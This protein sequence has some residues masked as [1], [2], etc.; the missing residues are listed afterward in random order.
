M[1]NKLITS[2]LMG[3][4]SMSALA[5]MEN[6]SARPKLVVGIMVDQLRTDYVEYLQVL[7]GEKGF[8]K[9][10]NDGVYFRNIDFEVPNL[11]V[12]NSTAMIYTG[13]YPSK[14]GVASAY[15]YIVRKH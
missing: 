7:F 15:I 9:L 12:V 10:M 11:D 8:K 1:K 4:V 14:N 6:T 5:Q 2:V 3:I 13:N